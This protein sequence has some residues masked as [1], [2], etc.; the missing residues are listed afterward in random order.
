MTKVTK[1]LKQEQIEKF[2]KDKKSI[3]PNS[4]RANKITLKDLNIEKML[5]IKEIKRGLLKKKNRFYM[6][7]IRTFVL[8]SEPRL[9]YYKNETEFKGEITYGSEAFQAVNTTEDLHSERLEN[10]GSRRMGPIY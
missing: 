10:R 4:S 3:K 1:D 2:I 8:T 6:Q 7:Q 5:Q 9:K